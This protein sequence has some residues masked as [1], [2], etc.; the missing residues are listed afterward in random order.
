MT[1]QNLPLSFLLSGVLVAAPVLGQTE[2]EHGSHVHGRSEIKLAVDATA[3]ELVLTA[4]GAD[5]VG[6]EHAPAD[7]AQQARID[8]ALARLDDAGG[9]LSF[10]PASVCRI[11]ETDAHTHGFKAEAE[12]GHEHGHGEHAGHGH[13]DENGHDHAHDHAHAEFHVTIKGSCSAAPGAALIDLHR[14]FDHIERVVVD[15]ITERSQNRVELHAGQ[16]RV[17]LD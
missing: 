2:R 7:A 1:R 16:N 9:W 11:D 14:H 10:V 3:F 5:I 15:V 6:F 12:E 4:P 13:A 17:G 8:A